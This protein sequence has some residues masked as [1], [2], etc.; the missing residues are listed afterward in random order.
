MLPLRNSVLHG[1]H[2][3]QGIRPLQS[4]QNHSMSN[5]KRTNGGAAQEC[6]RNH[7][8]G[9]CCEPAL[10]FVRIIFVEVRCPSCTAKVSANITIFERPVAIEYHPIFFPGEDLCRSTETIVVEMN[11]R[12][13]AS[14]SCRAPSRVVAWV[15]CL[16]KASCSMSLEPCP[17]IGGQV[18]FVNSLV[19]AG[20]EIAKRRTEVWEC[21]Q[22]P[23]H[24]GARRGRGGHVHQPPHAIAL[25][26]QP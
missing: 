24:Q 19:R 17:S 7:L 22:G 10:Q 1:E 18:S 2:I 9:L 13:R 4:K 6:P 3:V 12:S 11:P 20:P 14:R 23:T 15:R 8:N 26:F 16:S 21:Q 5:N 25:R